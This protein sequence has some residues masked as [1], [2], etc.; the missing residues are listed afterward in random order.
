MLSKSVCRRTKQDGPV[1]PKDAMRTV[2]EVIAGRCVAVL[3]AAGAIAGTP[4]TARDQTRVPPDAPATPRVDW[5]AFSQTD[6]K[7]PDPCS[8]LTKAELQKVTGRTADMQLRNMTD[9]LPSGQPVCTM[10]AGGGTTIE[11]II[12]SR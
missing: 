9:V 1:W 10:D 11:F 7:S 12:R 2:K 5:I 8:L 3:L 4:I 6:R